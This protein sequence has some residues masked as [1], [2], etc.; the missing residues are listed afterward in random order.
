MRFPS[1]I[2]T[3]GI[4]STV[5]VLFAA[6][7]TPYLGKWKMNAA[8]SDF[9]ESTI[10]YEATPSKDFKVIADGET[11]TF[12]MDGKDYPSFDGRTAAWKQLDE[13]TWQST[14]K[15]NGKT[16]WTRTTQVSPDGKTMR[17]E[18]KG[19]NPDGTPMHDTTVYERVSGSAGLVG[20]WKTKKVDSTAGVM[21]LAPHGA[22]GVT[23]TDTSMGSKVTANFD[24]KDY[25]ATGATF[26]PGYTTAL[27]KT[28]PNSFESTVKYEGKPLYV[29]RWVVSADGKTLT[30]T[31]EAVQAGEKYKVV[32][33]RQ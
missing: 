14:H 15:L 32:Y 1:L 33:D 2:L 31:G 4:L 21:E 20:K 9:G 27:K 10:T 11:R 5:G 17:V 28:G 29:S 19:N 23:W 30:E 16:L 24:G 13:R 18:L 25:P 3:L 6:Q 7:D 22:D 26:G 8:R 12:R